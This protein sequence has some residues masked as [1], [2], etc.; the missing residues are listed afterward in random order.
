MNTPNPRSNF[1][2]VKRRLGNVVSG[3]I[4]VMSFGNTNSTIICCYQLIFSVIKSRNIE[5]KYRF[6]KILYATRKLCDDDK[7]MCPFIDDNGISKQ[8]I[9]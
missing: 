8:K 3:R 4:I 5:K 1:Y 6:L 2:I 9:V 7:K